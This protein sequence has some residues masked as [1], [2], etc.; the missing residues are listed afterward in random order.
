MSPPLRTLAALLLLAAPAVCQDGPPLDVHGDPLPGGALA[1]LGSTRLRHDAA[2]LAVGFGPEGELVTFGAD[3]ALVRWDAEDGHEFAR[4][5]FDGARPVHAAASDTAL[6]VATSESTVAVL[7]PST[8]DVLA[9]LDQRGER[10]WPSPDGTLVC[11]ASEASVV[12]VERATGAERARFDSPYTV[13]AAAWSP[14][15][16]RLA[17]VAENRPKQLGRAGTE[18]QPD[19]MLHVLAGDGTGP[20]F[21]IVGDV[22]LHVAWAPDGAAL[23]A[24]G[25]AGVVR[26][27]DP[28]SGAELRQLVGGEALVEAL[29]VA[30][31]GRVAAGDRDGWLR[32]WEPAES[33]PV[34]QAPTGAPAVRALTFSPDGRALVAATGNAARLF[35]PGA[36]RELLA[37]PRHAGALSAAAVS[38]DGAW[39]A[40]GDFGGVVHLWRSDGTHVRA[41]EGAAGD[42]HEGRVSAL[43]FS[44]DGARLLSAGQ[45]G[46]AALWTVAD[47]AFERAF[48]GHRAAVTDAAFARQGALV[49]TA[50]GDGTAAVWSVESGEAERRIEGLSG[51]AP[52]LEVAGGT[53]LVAG[54]DVRAYDLATG[55]ERARRERLGSFATALAVAPDGAAIVGLARGKVLRWTPASDELA[56]LPV[57]HRGRVSAVAAAAGRGASVATGD[58][59]VRVWT[60]ATGEVVADVDVRGVSALALG[61]RGATLVVGNLDGSAYVFRVSDG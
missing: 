42:A 17:V 35:E 45:D 27:F 5:A 8:G 33:A 31:D 32:V 25:S 57:A 3:R 14:D 60:L 53:L 49:V 21:P 61:P 23:H 15:N 52:I 22:L 9:L 58:A 12:L 50:S 1:R 51:V 47:G 20:S 19:S 24:A 6:A 43:V 41:L 48:L 44:A 34:A 39:I 7:H 16:A 36:L 2:V 59:A 4:R 29:T 26:T 10:A 56:E 18:D 40:T 46:I 28:V 38:P 55:E 13:R 11:I 30:P 54:N 37:F